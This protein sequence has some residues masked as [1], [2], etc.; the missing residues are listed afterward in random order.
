[1]WRRDAWPIANWNKRP[2]LVT[3]LVTGHMLWLGRSMQT[4]QSDNTLKTN[5]IQ[6]IMDKELYGV[7]KHFQNHHFNTICLHLITDYPLIAEYSFFGTDNAF[8]MVFLS[9][10]S[11]YI[12]YKVYGSM[13]TSRSE[14]N[15]SKIGVV[16][17]WYMRRK[18]KISNNLQM[19]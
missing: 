3:T 6:I 5:W 16:L 12:I 8:C 4:E 14:R 9:L 10:C 17:R 2:Y 18:L 11:V 7:N 19:K 15:G 1:M 13:L